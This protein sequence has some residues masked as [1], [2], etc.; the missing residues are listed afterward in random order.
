MAPGCREEQSG[1]DL[2]AYANSGPLASCE[3]DYTWDTSL[4][5]AGYEVSGGSAS[6]L[7]YDN[8]GRL[9]TVSSYGATHTHGFIPGTGTLSSL[10][11]SGTSL[12]LTRTLYHDRMQRLFGIVTSN[13]SGTPLS[14]HGYTLDAAGRRIRATRE[15]GQRWDY[16]YDDVGQVT[17]GVKKFPDTTA[18][19]GHA[20]SYQYDG[21]GNRTSATHGGTG[22]DVTY[23]PS[24]LNQYTEIET[25]GG[26]FILG[27]APLANDVFINGD[28]TAADRAGGLGFYWKQIT[29]NNST[30]PLWSNDSVV[31]DG[32]TITGNTW[33][34]QNSVAPVYD[35]DGNLTYD[36]RW[37]YS[38]D[39]ENR[40]TRMQTTADAATAGVP[41]QRLDFVY[42]SQNRRVSKTVSTSE[43]G[44]TW[45]FASNLGFL[46]DGWNLI[47][48]YSAPS[49]ESTT[50]TLQ[51]AHVWG[52]DL[53]GTL[54]GAGG[55]G[56]LLASHLFNPG[57]T[58][59]PAFDGNGNI[60]AWLD[61]S[62]FLLSRMDYSPFGQ[63][64]AQYKFTGT[65]DTTLS[66]LPFGFSTKYTDKET[67]IVYYGHRYYD[68]VTGRWAAR[69]PFE[70]QGGLNLYGFIGNGGIN[71]LDLLGR[72]DLAAAMADVSQAWYAV[73]CRVFPAGT[74]EGDMIRG[75]IPTTYAPPP[76]QPAPAP[77]PQSS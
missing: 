30:G 48:E 27:E 32:V 38:W 56:G 41:R 51:A 70:E 59:Y 28:T 72:E 22:T 7:T 58:C 54:Q 66:R 34:P 33:T 21:I 49:A 76:A 20:F 57:A 46:Y 14:R 29:G 3:V 25:E 62:G 2:V 61:S 8:A 35:F 13:A 44:T 64:V 67:G 24:A 45:T 39:A 75:T 69:D 68:P 47:A 10:T 6:V 43:D 65:G 12:I 55:V 16:G 74:A 53:S 23:T 18:I 73:A 36:G 31:S 50:L 52:I 9:N 77:P 63:L 4:R 37:N 19:P 60:S 42:D 11:T 5:P 26:R 15:N 17:S 40:L 1:L 71:D